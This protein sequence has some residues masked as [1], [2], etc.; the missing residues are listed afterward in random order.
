LQKAGY[1]DLGP[2]LLN[3]PFDQVFNQA[4]ALVRQRG[5]TI[6][7]ASA[8]VGRIEAISTTPLMGFKDDV[9]IRI[10][11]EGVHVRVDMRSASRVGKSDLGANA[12]RI[13][14]FMADLD[15]Q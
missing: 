13:R 6:A 10:Q 15:R 4:V 12:A 3:R 14:A 1:P 11:A 9:A 7:S 8:S 5:W 2:L